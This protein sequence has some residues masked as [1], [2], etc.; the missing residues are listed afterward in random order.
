LSLR[1]IQFLHCKLLLCIFFSCL[2]ALWS[3]NVLASN[4]D[5][6]G[7]KND[8]VLTNVNAHIESIEPPA[9]NYQFEQYQLQLI[10]KVKLAVE[11]FGYYQ[12]QVDVT[13][14]D[15]NIKNSQW[16]V[17]VALGKET[18]ISQLLIDI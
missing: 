3:A 5:V 15:P 13:L 11:V 18:T 17:A 14:P 6:T 1:I 8:K 12:T 16:Q 9:A 4:V 2:A 7:I 10:E